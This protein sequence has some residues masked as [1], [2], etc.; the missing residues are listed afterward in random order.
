[1]NPRLVRFFSVL[2]GFI[3]GL[4]FM[5]KWAACSGSKIAQPQE[6]VTTKVVY[7]SVVRSIASPAKYIRILDSIFYPVQEDVCVDTAEIIRQYFTAYYQTQ[8]LRDSLLEAVIEDT[9]FANHIT[10][11]GF[12]Y[13]ILKPVSI[14]ERKIIPEKRF[15]LYAGGDV[16]M[17]K[18]SFGLSPMLLLTDKSGQAYHIRSDVFMPQPNFA[19]GV[20][21]KIG[22]Q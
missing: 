22:K 13:K 2:S 11:R 18:N 10:W 15:H 7:D 3:I 16:S 6:I 17:H 21:F 14:T 5:N 20:H 1:M 19:L 9:L 4:L 12:S 8:T